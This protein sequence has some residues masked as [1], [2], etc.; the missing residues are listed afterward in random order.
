MPKSRLDFWQPKLN[1]NVERDRRNLERLEAEGWTAV[2]I[3]ECETRD[4]A[5][6]GEFVG[7]IESFVKSGFAK[8]KIVVAKS[9]SPSP[10]V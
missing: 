10:M 6:L 3:W 8:Q 7:R 4:S 1:A 9:D 5:R 2:T